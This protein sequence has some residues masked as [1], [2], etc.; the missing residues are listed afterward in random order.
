MKEIILPEGFEID[1]EKST[2]DKVILKEVEKK[3][4]P[5]SINDLGTHP[6]YSWS[7]SLLKAEHKPPFVNGFVSEKQSRSA[8][9]YQ[10][11]GFLLKEYNGDWEPD[12]SN[13]TQIKYILERVGQKIEMDR[14]YTI[15]HFLAFP[16]PELRDKFLSHFERLIKDYFELD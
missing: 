12:W 13:K 3:K 1:F 2:K 8:R 9:A 15:Y 10:L 11:L 6:M 7:G 14:I 16:T 4:L 5:E